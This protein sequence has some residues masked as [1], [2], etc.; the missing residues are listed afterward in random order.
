MSLCPSDTVQASG[1]ISGA[2]LHDQNLAL[3]FACKIFNSQMYS[4]NKKAASAV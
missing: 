1:S 4:W 3:Y 2:K